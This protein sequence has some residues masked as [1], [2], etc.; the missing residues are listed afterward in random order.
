MFRPLLAIFRMYSRELKV[1]LYI[2]IYIYIYL[3]A[4]VREIS[5]SGLCCVICIFYVESGGVL[6]L[7]ARYLHDVSSF[8]IHNRDDTLPSIE[9]SVLVLLNHQHTL[10]MGTYLAAETSE[11]L[12]I[13]TRLSARENLI[14]FCLL[15]SFKIRNE[16]NSLSLNLSKKWFFTSVLSH[17]KCVLFE[18]YFKTHNFSL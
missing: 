9:S 14:E 16:V 11:N 3:R 10:K 8:H 17:Y 2:Y 18:P 7:E 5:T 15:E 13:L 12:H 6:R 4:R 1:L